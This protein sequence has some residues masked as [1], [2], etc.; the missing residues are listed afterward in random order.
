VGE[1]LAGLFVLETFF[2]EPG[3]FDTY[4]ALSPSLWWNDQALVRAAGERLKTQARADGTLY[5]ATTG[6][7]GMAD[8]CKEL[9]EA[10]RANAQPG[11]TWHY[12]PRP[13]LLHSNIYRAAS[14]GV[15]RK[16]F[17]SANKTA[18]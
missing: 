1:S 18:R 16:L 12:E 17:P 11:L 3:L 9:A 2:Q 4:I 5:F 14:P 13:D 7:D 8:V 15:F 6:D 10:L